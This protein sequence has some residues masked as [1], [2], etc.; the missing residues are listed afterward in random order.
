MSEFLLGLALIWIAATGMG[1]LAV[2]LGQPRV[3]GEII[4]G[5]L[6]GPSVLGIE[7]ARAVF[8]QQS[9]F[10]LRVL[11]TI[12]LISFMYTVGLDFDMR[13]LK[14]SWSK[15]ILLALA[16]A[17]IPAALAWPLASILPQAGFMQPGADPVAY[18]WF[19]AAALSVSAF[20]VAAVILYE[21]EMI[22][23]P[24]GELGIG[25]TAVVTVLMFVLLAYAEGIATGAP[26]SALGAK[27]LGLAL[28]LV[29][30]FLV[31]Q[32]GWDHLARRN[33]DL[34][35]RA[36]SVHIVFVFVLAVI[37]AVATRLLGFTFLLG[38]FLL[39][40]AVIPNPGLRRRLSDPL[41]WS[42]RWL[43]LP[44]FFV[45]SGLSTNL[46][47]ITP[48]MVFPILLVVLI[49]VVGKL[50]AIIPTGR[51]LGLPWKESFLLA[52]LLNCRGLLVLVIALA[53]QELGLIGP[54]LFIALVALSLLSTIMT[55]P[56]INLA[57]GPRTKPSL[58][59]S[60]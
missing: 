22:D 48:A 14:G 26:L 23:S 53:G 49:G 50:G 37:T 42:T 3:V 34:F 45:V 9:L 13:V 46:R 40:A 18:R 1:W 25:T 21:L 54:G 20:P 19:L 51:A 12:G 27:L 30:L 33:P 41:R 47:L 32:P 55:G 5:V 17:A 58:G 4:A 11:A 36:S 38:P 35:Q 15:V 6:L 39:G 24:L 31:F 44:I 10:A 8:P 7:L 2:R 28:L 43:L 56:L 16:S 57:T 60:T 52:S 59:D 29:F